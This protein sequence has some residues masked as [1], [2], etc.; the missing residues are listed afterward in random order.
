M[1][2]TRLCGATGGKM[3]SDL[4]VRRKREGKGSE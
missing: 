1:L 3:E 2:N 4:I